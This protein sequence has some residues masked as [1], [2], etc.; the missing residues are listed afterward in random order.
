MADPHTTSWRSLAAVGLTALLTV[1]AADRALT[2]VS[3][4]PP[5]IMEV[6]DGVRMV[7]EGN[8][9]VL[10][11]G[12]SHT[13]SFVPM[14]KLLADRDGPEMALVPVEWGVFTSYR[15]V[16]ENRLAPLIDERK[17]GALARPRLSRAI[18][19]TTFY[20][21]CDVEHIGNVNLP[22]RAW[23]LSHFVADVRVH[24]LTEFNR[25]FLQTRWKALFPGSVLIQDRGYER[26]SD[27]LRDVIR[28][29]DDE[30]RAEIRAERVEWAT[31]NMENQYATCWHPPELAALDDILSFFAARGIEATVV[32]FPLLPDIVS[33]K[34][35]RTTL[36]RYEA[37]VADLGERVRVV[38]MT[39]GAPVSGRD[40]Q[41]DFDHLT[42]A[43][44]PRFSA[45]ALDAKMS[46]LLEP[47]PGRK[48]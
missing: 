30:R 13:R 38:D 44:N 9:D 21:M 5:A 31:K 24:G 41:E 3:P 26:V 40:F 43:A 46:F 1:V 47:A 28:P 10:V 33:D 39:Y 6:D 22:A 37:Y 36:A 12:S 48:P 8:P 20:D 15:W 16:L 45:W 7:R 29:I 18:L 34:S 17:D 25:N 2:V 19:I 32:A 42:S 11:L 4:I 27:A 14:R 35:K 23:E